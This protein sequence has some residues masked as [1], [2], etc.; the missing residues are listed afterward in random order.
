M[1]GTELR[2]KC[3]QIMRAQGSEE[4][5]GQ[6]KITPGYHLPAK[7]V[8]HT[9]GPVVSGLLTQK[10][11]TLLSSCY[12]S[13]LDLAEAYHLTSI[14]FCCI[15]TGVFH[16]P[17]DKAA[18]IAVQSVLQW[19]DRHPKTHLDRIIFNVFKDRDRQI[20]EEILNGA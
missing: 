19:R 10:D 2:E 8:I 7:Y 1:A 11:R 20:Y 5:T 3:Y 12:L 13:V 4:P 15:S 14:A 17:Q 6:A 16:F 9:V 18:E